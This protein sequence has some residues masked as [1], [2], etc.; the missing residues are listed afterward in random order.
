MHKVK[1]PEILDSL[2]A[3]DKI[4]HLNTSGIIRLKDD[5]DLFVDD[6]KDPDGYIITKDDWYI[7]YYKE[8]AREDVLEMAVEKPR[9]FSGV[10]KR[11][12]DDIREKRKIDFHEI[13][14]LYYLEADD[15]NYKEPEYEIESLTVE[16]AKV[17]DEHY[18]YQSEDDT[19]F[20]YIKKTIQERP[21][22]VIRDDEGNPISW[23]VVRDDGSMGIAYTL[24]EYRRQ[25][26]AAAVNMEL[27]KRT[28]D[29]GLM[30]YVHIV[31]DNRASISLAE[32]LGF[33]RNGKVVW[34]ATK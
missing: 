28:I 14:Y 13:C 30:P 31:T 3:D 16:D 1:Q 27:L 9:K 24:E 23:S 10:H 33:K 5:Y 32:R 20:E 4:A 34:F 26:Y 29:F 25:G 22:A 12:F 21:T 18:T 8:E 15:F 7:V 11:F 17:V 6:L 2:I 19:S